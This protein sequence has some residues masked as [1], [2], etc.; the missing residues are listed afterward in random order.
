VDPGAII[1]GFTGPIGSGC[2]F[3]SKSLSEE[4]GQFKYAKVSDIIRDHLKSEGV[5]NPSVEDMQTKGNQLRKEHGGH[6]LVEKT[7]EK[8]TGSEGANAFILDGIKNTEEVTYLRF[9]S[10]F[11]LFSVHASKEVRRERSVGQE[12][13][14]L[15]ADEFDKI[16]K[17]DEQENE[18]HGQQVKGCDYL[19]DII[20]LNNDRYQQFPSGRKRDFIAG[21]YRKYV[22]RI[23]DLRDN[24]LDPDYRPSTD[25]LA[26]TSAY[27]QSKKSSCL[28]RK[29]GAVIIDERG[30]NTNKMPFII[31][32][33]YNEVP[34]GSEACMHEFGKCYRDYAQER[35]ASKI[36]CCPRCGKEFRIE[37]VCHHCNKTFD[38]YVKTCDQCHNEISPRAIHS[39]CDADIF[40]EFVMG[41]KDTPGKLMDL[42]RALHAEENALLNL[43][44]NYRSSPENLILYTTTQP[45][46]LCANKIVASG[47]KKVVFAEPYFM[48]HSAV[49]LERAGVT[50]ERFEGVKSYAYFKLYK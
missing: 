33:G 36:R 45:C 20:L 32:S 12:K 6:Y 38:R 37:A 2:S 29:V 9:F 14:I 50:V 21:I 16:D 7:L 10:H 26:M 27:I 24:K 3:V 23:L 41:S 5:E 40:R 22:Q 8:L 30:F 44:S 35:Q 4:F 46:N 39:D 1:L 11:F 42:C 47:I 15:S 48:E 49:V 34:T 18:R 31:S 25:E 17:R 43:V 13:R 28:K 19:S